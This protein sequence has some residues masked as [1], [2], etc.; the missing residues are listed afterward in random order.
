[1]FTARQLLSLKPGTIIHGTTARGAAIRLKLTNVRLVARGAPGLGRVELTGVDA[2]AAARHDAARRAAQ[3]RLP[4]AGCARARRIHPHDQHAPRQARGAGV[5]GR[6]E[7]GLT[8][9]HHHHP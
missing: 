6:R 9:S 4:R 2:D 1:M 5:P 7:G 8:P 3:R